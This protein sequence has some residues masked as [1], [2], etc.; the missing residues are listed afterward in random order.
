MAT[1]DAKS[2]LERA[3]EAAANSYA[4]YSNE[5]KGAAIL[6]SDGTVFASG[7]VEF[8]TFGGSVC[9]ELGAL[10]RA[11]NEGK[12]EF[13]AIALHPHRYPCGNCRQFL[14]EFG[15]DLDVI[16]SKPD[17]SIDSRPLPAFLPNS[18]GKSNLG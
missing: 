8:A 9:A 13:K 2:L 1:Y 4:P 17:G 12:R 14:S 6:A 18:F 5:P 10:T 11:I 15:L 16:T 7:N 3:R